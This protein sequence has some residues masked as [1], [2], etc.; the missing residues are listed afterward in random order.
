MAKDILKKAEEAGAEILIAASNRCACHLKAAT[1]GWNTSPV[2][3]M[4]IYSFLASRLGG[5]D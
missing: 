3:V 1:G 4:D 5:G 2:K